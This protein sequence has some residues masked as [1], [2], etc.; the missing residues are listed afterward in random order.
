MPK[1]GYGERNVLGQEVPASIPRLRRPDDYHTGLSHMNLRPQSA[2][3]SR[4]Y[5]ASSAA[6][7][8]PRASP[9]DSARRSRTLSPRSSPRAGP[10]GNLH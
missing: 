10:G 6:D 3:S 4:I 8:S 5:G 1:L 7:G 9:L 2:H